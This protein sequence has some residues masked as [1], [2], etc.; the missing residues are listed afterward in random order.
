MVLLFLLAV[1]AVVIA[2]DLVLAGVWIWGVSEVRPV[3]PG[4]TPG[5][6]TLIR[7][8]P[9]AL[10]LWGAVGTAALILIVSTVNVAQLSDGGE[11]VAKMVGA[12]RVSPET[13]DPLERRFLNVV[14][15]MAI[16]SGV[17]IPTAYIMDGEQGINA[18]AA[19]GDVSGAVGAGKRGALQ[20]LTPDAV[21]GVI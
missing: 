9:L 14:E 2:V 1:L 11:A 20:T 21:H 6:L 12:R 10:Y 3:E 8:V 18:F 17:R 19:G 5:L 7:S 16:A 13:R 15:E 4:R